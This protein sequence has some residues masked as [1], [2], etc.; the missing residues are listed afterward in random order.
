M[1]EGGGQTL[2]WLETDQGANFSLS[3]PQLLFGGVCVGGGSGWGK[4]MS[5]IPPHPK[6]PTPMRSKL[7]VPTFV[8]V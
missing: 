6:L 7:L 8:Y 2:S 5:S 3:P 1:W 4:G